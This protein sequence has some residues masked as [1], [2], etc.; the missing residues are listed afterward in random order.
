M[1]LFI[2]V[3]IYEDVVHKISFGPYE[4]FFQAHPPLELVG[5]L[6]AVLGVAFAVWARV[7]LASN[8]GMPMTLRENPKLVTT[9]PYRYVRH[10][11]YTGVILALFG[12]TVVSG[13]WWALIFIASV[14]YF[15][16]SAFQEERD[17][18][19]KFPDTYPAYKARTKMLIPFVL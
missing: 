19:E 12:S 9:G 5:A 17:L 8:W 11:I 18:V 14:F 15:T 16:V 13:T 7:Y 10:P 6:C 2:V 3:L 1:Y 4:A